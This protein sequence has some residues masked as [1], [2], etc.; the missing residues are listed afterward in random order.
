MMR[1]LFSIDG[2]FT[3]SCSLLRVCIATKQCL[4]HLGQNG[5][6]GSSEFLFIYLHLTIVLNSDRGMRGTATE[7]NLF[8]LLCMQ[9]PQVLSNV[10]AIR[11]LP[12]APQKGCI[13]R[14][15]NWCLLLACLPQTSRTSST[16]RR[17]LCLA[18]Q[19][20]SI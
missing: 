8:N 10:P 15:L 9:A 20:L 4:Q 1:Y 2:V 5:L 19:P 16:T 3:A 14:R 11:S 13:S 17:V 6:S 7:T 18:K 12:Q